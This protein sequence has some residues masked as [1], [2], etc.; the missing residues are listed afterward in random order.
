LLRV[1]G[2]SRFRDKAT[3]MQ[4]L[5]I[6][7]GADQALYRSLFEALGYKNNKAS[8][9]CIAQKLP[10]SFI[11][12]LPSPAARMAAVFGVAGLLPDPSTT[13]VL[14]ALRKRISQLWDHWWQLGLAAAEV[15]VSRAC[16]RPLNYP[17]RRLAAGLRWL[18]N[19]GCQ[20]AQTLIRIAARAGD[21]KE[22]LK[23]LH[24]E[25]AFTTEWDAIATFT[26]CLPHPAHL[27][28]RNRVNDII[29]NVFLPFLKARA[30]RTDNSELASLAEETFLACPRLQS[31]RPVTEVAHRLLVPPSRIEAVAC[32][33]AEQQGLLALH[34][35]FCIALDGNCAN[36]PLQNP[37]ELE[38]VLAA[39]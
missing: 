33:A 5:I 4:R 37:V 16:T 20:P 29:I 34:T 19:W 28:G 23:R 6:A 15:S 3:A 17:E 35:D 7:K 22:L 12:S 18:E 36:C 39:E 8:F 26:R 9:R 25:F 2:L 13:P 10:L 14:P 1:A 21:A 30:V 11:R 31:N 32:R 27:V 24:T 38:K